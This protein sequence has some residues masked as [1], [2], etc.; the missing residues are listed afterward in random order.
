MSTKSP[1]GYLGYYINRFSN[2]II[3]DHEIFAE[4]PFITTDLLILRGSAYGNRPE[5]AGA[6]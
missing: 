4:K 2:V 6:D 5:G 3:N 1:C